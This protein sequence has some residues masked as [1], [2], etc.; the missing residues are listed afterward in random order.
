MSAFPSFLHAKIGEWQGQHFS[1]LEKICR[2]RGLPSSTY[3]L[4]D[5]NK[6]GGGSSSPSGSRSGSNQNSPNDGE[7]GSNTGVNRPRS[8]SSWDKKDGTNRMDVDGNDD[9]GGKSGSENA[10]ATIEERKQNWLIDRLVNYDLY[11]Y[12]K[13]RAERYNPDS[14]QAGYRAGSGE[15]SGGP[16]GRGEGVDGGEDC[17]HL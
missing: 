9:N 10:F 15:E 8:K 16:A 5:S 4:T 2:S 17:K 7:G 12:E 13:E 1:Q 11:W 6:Q 3:H 14:N